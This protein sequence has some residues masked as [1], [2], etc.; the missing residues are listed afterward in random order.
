MCRKRTCLA[1]LVLVLGCTLAS[2]GD[3]DLGKGL[4]AWWTF[5]EGT[6]NIAYDGS[7]NNNNATLMGGATWTTPGAPGKEG[8][9]ISLNGTSAFLRVEHSPSLDVTNA[10]TFEMWVY[11]TGTPAD[12][13][14]GQGRRRRRKRLEEPGHSPRRRPGDVPAVELA[15][16]RRRHRQRPELRDAA[17]RCRSGPTSPSPSTWTPRET[18]RRSTST[19]N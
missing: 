15:Q 8:Y 1:C 6:G 4:V 16:P 19:G 5:D 9:A 10:V 17:C 11:Y 13:D 2:Y 7:G 18:T 14:H 3:V 12:A